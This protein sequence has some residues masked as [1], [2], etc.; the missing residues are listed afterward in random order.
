MMT[1]DDLPCRDGSCELGPY[2]SGA[3]AD[4]RRRAFIL[5]CV[6]SAASEMDAPT[7]C[8]MV[9]DLAEMLRTGAVP[10][11]ARKLRPVS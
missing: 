8:Q 3:N 11:K 1:D 2:P 6:G 9:L 7:L 4:E 5:E 10:S